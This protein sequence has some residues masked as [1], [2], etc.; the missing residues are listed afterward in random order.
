M[1][2]ATNSNGIIIEFKDR[3]AANGELC[4]GYYWLMRKEFHM[5]LGCPPTPLTASRSQR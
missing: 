5:V 3:G 1:N 2:S 4:V